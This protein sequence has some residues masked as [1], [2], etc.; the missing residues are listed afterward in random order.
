[1]S[2][3]IGIRRETKPGER[4]TPLTPIAVKQL[5]EE[6]DVQTILQPFDKRAFSDEEYKEAGALI[7]EDLSECSVVFGIKEMDLDIFLPDKAFMCFH[8]VIK[9]QESNMPMLKHIMKTGSTMFDY[10]KVT[11]D[12]NRRL[13][14]F[15]RHAGYAGMIDTLHGF[16][17]RL[18]EME[19][20]DSPFLKIKQSCDYFDLKE[21]KEE[22]TKVAE[23]IKKD[24]LPDKLFPLVFGFLGYGNVSQGAQMI[25]DL[26]P[27][28]EIA[29]EELA[30][31]VAC[32]DVDECKTTI[33]K[34]VFKEEHMVKPK[35][36]KAKFVLQDYYDNPEKYEGCFAEEYLEYI[37]V[38]VN[39][40]YWSDKY[41]KTITKEDIKELF[42]DDKEPRLRF[43]GDI[44]C[45]VEGGVEAT[46]RISY[47]ERP[48][49][50]YD[51]EEDT[52]TD[53]VKGSGPAIL[54]IDHLPTEIPRDASEYF[55]NT[56]LP[57]VP[58]MAKAKYDGTLDEAG[59]AEEIKRSV[60]LWK[61]KFTPDFEYIDEY[62]K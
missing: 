5:K 54:A 52:A 33:Y 39:G 13:I 49:F 35:D 30:E 25:L 15:G 44:S 2:H 62:L 24:G 60:I 51:P 20:L 1:M 27:V 45:D 41:P 12:K 16:G 48:F 6:H 56:L 37:T 38:I 42:C 43:I 61:G 14:F 4:R 58:N 18:K 32:P 22:I 26:L 11:D 47:I 21:A 8:H 40:A 9:G 57:F 34:V 10:E 17:L 59:L 7:N 19:G 53:G 50:C 23:I 31:L 36:A 28:K 3:K 29:P 55:S 46:V